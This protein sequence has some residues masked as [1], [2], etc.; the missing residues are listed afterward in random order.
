MSR[1]ATLGAHWLH[2]L[3]PTSNHPVGLGFP[4]M[5]R[6]RPGGSALSFP[7]YISRDME[8]FLILDGNLSS[9]GVPGSLRCPEGQLSPRAGSTNL[10][11][12]AITQWGWDFHI[13]RGSIDP[14]GVCFRPR[15]V[16]CRGMQGFLIRGQNRIL[17]ECGEKLTLA[18]SA[19]PAARWLHE[20][21]SFSNQPMR[22]GFPHR[23]ERYRP[24]GSALLSRVV[25]VVEIRKDF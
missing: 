12:S 3:Q 15:V 25:G 16:G 18:S 2:E 21:Q 4:H 14:G 7:S 22:L 19:T 23:A 8:G 17:P 20:P 6:Y 1:K 9:P 10:N 5:G 13:A 11:Q 24:G